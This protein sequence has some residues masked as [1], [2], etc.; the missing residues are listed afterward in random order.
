MKGEGGGR[1][2][3]SSGAR[4]VHTSC[5]GHAQCTPGLGQ[6]IVARSSSSSACLILVTA[7]PG[8]L[9]LILLFF[10][11]LSFIVHLFSFSGSSCAPPPILLLPIP[12][13][14]LSLL[15]HAPA[16]FVSRGECFSF[17]VGSPCSQDSH[18]E[19]CR[20][21]RA[22]PVVPRPTSLLHA[23]PS[24][25]HPSTA[26]RRWKLFQAAT[27]AGLAQGGQGVSAPLHRSP[28]C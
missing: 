20:L 14:P 25:P 18:S 23:T 10:F 27:P 22:A 2:G 21:E 19:D 6:R 17:S 24:L 12:L 7:I 5:W 1:G 26:R 8:V 11:L 13:A 9:A 4:S 3:H 16:I 28:A 15:P